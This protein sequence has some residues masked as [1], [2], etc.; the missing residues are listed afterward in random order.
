[1]KSSVRL[2]LSV[3][4]SED[5][6]QISTLRRKLSYWRSLK[7]LKRYV[8]L[9]DNMI[10]MDLGAGSGGF[11]NYVKQNL[12]DIKI[13]GVEYDPRLVE[14]ANRNLGEELVKQGDVCTLDVADNSVDVIVSLQVIEHLY[15]PE[16]FIKEVYRVLKPGGVFMFTT[17]NLQGLGRRI[18]GSR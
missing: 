13:E 5:K 2:D 1:M 10:M 15:E 8:S 3:K 4:Y 6:K 18:M 7:D 17:P 14:V 12:P 16:I 9:H 11:L